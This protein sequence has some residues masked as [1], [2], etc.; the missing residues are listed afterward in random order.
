VYD[1]KEQNLKP[2]N[3]NEPL[4][5]AF[6]AVATKTILLSWGMVFVFVVLNS[7]GA[8]AI[9]NE[10]I[11]IGNLKPQSISAYFYLLFI[12]WRTW[13]GLFSIAVGTCAWMLSLAQLEMSKAYPVAIG[14]NLLI[15]VGVS[16]L[17]FN[18]P[19][20][21]FKMLGIFFIAIGVLFI[22]Q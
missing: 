19:M 15:I 20:T 21:F 22:V 13:L 4:T 16:L 2:M 1:S 10:I 7:F 3:Q 17:C 14:L 12:S 11:K 8:L 18:E 6:V 5:K 9:K